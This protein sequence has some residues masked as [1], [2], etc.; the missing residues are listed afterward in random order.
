VSDYARVEAA[1]RFID[2]RYRDQPSLNEIASHVHLSAYHFQR[3]FRR[4]AGVSPK[5]FLQYLTVH[6]ATRLLRQSGS[7]LDVSQKLGLSGSSRLYDLLVNMHAVTPGEW[8]RLG[9]GLTIHYGFHASPFGECLI[10]VTQRGV[11]ALAFVATGGRARAVA[12]MKASW[13]GARFRRS[14]AI[15]H[16]VCSRIFTHA[17][18]LPVQPIDLFVRGSNFQIKVWEALL[19]I[20]SGALI[21]Y[22]SLAERLG[23]PRAARAV[24][25]A[26]A[27]NPVAVLIPCHRVIRSTGALGGYH[28]GE[29]RK[30][31]MLGWESAHS[32][33][34]R[35]V[36]ENSEESN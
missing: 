6:H 31:A 15:T 26:V 10:A 7:L 22:H 18:D 1:I 30:K 2:G 12:D 8:K 3:L 34:G 19:R 5:R 14:E 29:T 27:G 17:K 35:E 23:N 11:C 25:R 13:P 32:D 4:W 21:S 36:A 28:W 24:A 9:D 33:S 20:P 16:S